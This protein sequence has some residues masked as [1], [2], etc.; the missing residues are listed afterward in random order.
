M[1]QWM[2]QHWQEYIEHHQISYIVG[3]VQ[4]AL[5]EHCHS[6]TVCAARLQMYQKIEE[7]APHL[8]EY[9]LVPR[10]KRGGCFSTFSLAGFR[11][12]KRRRSAP[13]EIPQNC[14]E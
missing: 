11:W 7:F 8:P 12:L 3:E 1:H 9:H 6:C 13:R 5:D 2:H 10:R 4:A 14:H